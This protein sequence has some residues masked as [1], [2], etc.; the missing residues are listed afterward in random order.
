MTNYT[1]QTLKDIVFKRPNDADRFD[2]IA[3][4]QLKFPDSGINGVLFYGDYGTG[5]SSA[6]AMLPEIVES[7]NQHLSQALFEIEGSHCLPNRMDACGDMKIDLA[8][9]KK[10]E[11][12]LRT[13]PLFGSFH[14]TIIDEI[15]VLSRPH[16]TLVRNMMGRQSSVW[17]FTTN[18]LHRVDSG[19]LNRCILVDFEAA[20]PRNW[21]PL[22]RRI[23][24]DQGAL[25][26]S[27]QVMTQ[28]IFNCNGSARQIIQ[29]AKETAIAQI[30]A[31]RI[32]P[33]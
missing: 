27:D 7:A 1:P 25:P 8:K 5:K 2:L 9:L 33:P 28:A 16:Q 22:F 17:Y 29:A 19:I 23:V 24:S 12:A 15:D 4:G 30:R 14:H 21:L 10:I 32:L 11:P 13:V 20:P 3:Q 26:P 31:G 6:A 18:H